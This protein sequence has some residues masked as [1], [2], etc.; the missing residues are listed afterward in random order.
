[1][2]AMEASAGDAS[3]CPTPKRTLPAARASNV[4]K[5]GMRKS[6]QDEAIPPAATRKFRGSLSATRPVY[7]WRN[8]VASEFS[9]TTIPIFFFFFYRPDASIGSIMSMDPLQTAERN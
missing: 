6:V 7:P 1:M 3:A 4:P 9:E 8:P 2:A 5:N